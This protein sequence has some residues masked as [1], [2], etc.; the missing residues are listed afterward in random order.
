MRYYFIIDP[1][2]FI[3]SQRESLL[4]SKP[5]K[6]PGHEAR[7]LSSA[8]VKGYARATSPGATG[9]ASHLHRGPQFPISVLLLPESSTT[10]FPCHRKETK[11]KAVLSPSSYLFFSSRLRYFLLFLLFV[12]VWFFFVLV[13]FSTGT[14]TCF[15]FTGSSL[16]TSSR[17]VT[18]LQTFLFFFFFQDSG[19]QN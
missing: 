18:W 5:Q 19:S 12:L 3:L 1:R 8:D 17:F 14:I 4:E 6:L 15:V 9:I 2:P 11:L 7:T 10:N 13:F 16:M